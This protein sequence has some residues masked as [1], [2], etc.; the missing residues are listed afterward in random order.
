MSVDSLSKCLDS[1][2]QVRSMS[3]QQLV[4]RLQ[5]EAARNYSLSVSWKA[6][7]QLGAMSQAQADDW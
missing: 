1:L 4:E 3:S 5:A 6:L 7:R 2:Q